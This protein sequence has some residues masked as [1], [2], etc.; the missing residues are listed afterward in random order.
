[1]KISQW[2]PEH[3]EELWLVCKLMGAVPVRWHMTPGSSLAH[4]L[5]CLVGQMEE[6]QLPHS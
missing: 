5:S 2:L 1:M 4:L 3:M 6:G